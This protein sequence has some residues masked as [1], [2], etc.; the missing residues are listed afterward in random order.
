VISDDE[1]TFIQGLIYENCNITLKWNERYV[2]CEEN[3]IVSVCSINRCIDGFYHNVKRQGLKRSVGTTINHHRC[4]ENMQSDIFRIWRITAK[5]FFV[6]AFEVNIGI[7][8]VYGR[9]LRGTQAVHVVRAI[10]SRNI[11][12]YQQFILTR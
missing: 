6:E 1:R 3:K 12:V 9:S 10:K 8:T 5:Y 2:E 4:G 7:R 11:S